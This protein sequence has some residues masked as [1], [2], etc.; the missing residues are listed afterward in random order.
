MAESKR[1]RSLRTT[2]RVSG[3]NRP[4]GLRLY[5]YAVNGKLHGE[6]KTLHVVCCHAS[7]AR[8]MVAT[9]QPEIDA[10]RVRRGN[11]VHFIA[12]GDHALIE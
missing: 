8:A 2:R 4:Q 11:L 6:R 12:V 1:P 3:S 5:L 9:H 10:L 7:D